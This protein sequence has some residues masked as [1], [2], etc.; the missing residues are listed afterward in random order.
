MKSYELAA[1]VVRPCASGVWAFTTGLMLAIVS[2]ALSQQ[3]PAGAG[4]APPL[5]VMLVAEWSGGEGVVVSEKDA[6]LSK[7]LAMVPAWAR[8][9]FAMIPEGEGPPPEALETLLDFVTHPTRIA[10]THRGFDEQTGMPRVGAIVS[11]NTGA[12][13]A[14]RQTAEAIHARLEKVRATI[15][16][17]FQAGPSARAKGMTDIQLPIGILTYGPREAA[18]GWRFEL[19]FADVADPDEAFVALPKPQDGVTPFLRARLDLAACSP[20]T[21]MALG[22]AAMASPDGASFIESARKFGVLGQEAIAVETV[23][24]TGADSRSAVFTLQRAGK[25]AQVWNQVQTPF[26]KEILAAIPADATAVGIQQHDLKAGWARLM[27]ELPPEAK[28]EVDS[29]LEQFRQIAGVD[30]GSDIVAALGTTCVM[31]LADSTGGGSLLS[32]VVMQELSDPERMSRSLKTV[33]SRLIEQASLQLPPQVR[34]A[35]GGFDRAGVSF[36]Q[37]RISGLPIPCEPTYAVVG[38]WLVVGGTPQATI[39]AAQWARAGAP[40]GGLAA[41]KVFQAAQWKASAE[42]V[43]MGYIASA[44]TLRDSY[45]TVSLLTSALANLVR[46]EGSRDPGLILPM[47][48]ELSEG[49]RPM[50]VQTY[51]RGD[52]LV[53]ETRADRSLLVALGGV[54][55]TGDLL[56]FFAGLALGGAIGSEAAQN[57]MHDDH[58]MPESEMEDDSDDEMDEEDGQPE[59]PAKPAQQEKP[60][61][62][63]STPY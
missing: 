30:F 10:I 23:L 59:A 5:Q 42:P 18:G 57:D 50:L 36:T 48:N 60:A 53:M 47:L 51:W 14:G 21:Q 54:L 38:K 26:A 35:V 2:P 61:E 6:A 63:P 19:M 22:F 46:K 8:E 17:E 37:I 33:A 7:A 29:A 39:L 9:M 13:D 55:G 16:M 52:D 44:R 1:R 24:G 58:S 25:Y 41:N 31:Y 32:G 12:G 34:F 56:P 62:R 20:L 43:A 4:Q 49:A 15:P 3:P 28:A 11:V 27:A 40:A 45:P